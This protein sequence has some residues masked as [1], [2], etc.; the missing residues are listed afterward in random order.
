MNDEVAERLIEQVSALRQSIDDTAKSLDD[1]Q[2]A[3]G[4]IEGWLESLSGHSMGRQNY[5]QVKVME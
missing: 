1:L 2:Q 5:L 3:V 4:N